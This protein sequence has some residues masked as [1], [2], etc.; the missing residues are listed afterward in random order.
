MTQYCQIIA[1]CVTEWA[2]NDKYTVYKSTDIFKTWTE[3]QMASR[4]HV[5]FEGLAHNLGLHHHPNPSSTRGSPQPELSK[6]MKFRHIDHLE[7]G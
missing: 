5:F 1:E 7:T 3:R 4:R 6:K 2:L